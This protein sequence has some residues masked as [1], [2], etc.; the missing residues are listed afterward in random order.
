M[1]ITRTT[2]RWAALTGLWTVVGLVVWLMA[3][4]VFIVLVTPFGAWQWPGI[5]KVT[6]KWVDR[7]PQSPYAENV[8]VIQGGVERNL[9]ML[10]VELR[11]LRP[12]DEIWILDNYYATATRPAQFRLTPTRL[13]LEYPLPLLLLALWGIRRLRRAQALEAQPDPNRPRTVLRDDF[14]TRAQRF[15]APKDPEGE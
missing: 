10:K 3:I 8:G 7:D 4:Q 11:E 9:S 2:W 5:A 15:A 6:V 14:H 12:D 1:A 13:I